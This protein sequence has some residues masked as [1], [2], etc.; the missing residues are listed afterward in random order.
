MEL[1]LSL[2]SVITAGVGFLG[3]YVLMPFALILRDYFLI[4]FINKFFLN[5]NF[6]QDLILLES[7]RAHCNYFYNKTTEV[8]HPIGGGNPECSIDGK[9]V[10]LEEFNSFERARG[11]HVERMGI[12]WKRME[13]KNN[14]A[15]KIFKY[16]K[17]NEYDDVIKNKSKELYDKTINSI[18]RKEASKG[19]E[20]PS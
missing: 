12:V 15:L 8:K 4:K 3:I 9:I 16:F 5:E 11:F 18:K 10:S 1:T 7:D 2:G 14:I 17:L 19:A 20:N 13:F 6:W